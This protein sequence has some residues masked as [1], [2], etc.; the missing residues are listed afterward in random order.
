[1]HWIE[2][3]SIARTSEYSHKRSEVMSTG[4]KTAS[5]VQSRSSFYFRLAPE[6]DKRKKKRDTRW[7]TK[8]G[9]REVPFNQKYLWALWRE[10]KLLTTENASLKE[11]K[12]RKQCGK[13]KYKLLHILPMTLSH[14]IV[15]GQNTAITE[16][17]PPAQ[18]SAQRGFQNEDCWRHL[19]RQPLTL[20]PIVTK[21]LFIFFS[22]SEYL[23][24]PC[25]T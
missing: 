3:H 10:A 7:R 24:A 11:K 2:Q 5:T 25:G 13:Q 6:K 14:T 9:W 23:R 8:C 19:C 12:T 21:P 1:M 15:L 4:R 17:E 22:A 16:T 20:L 18:C